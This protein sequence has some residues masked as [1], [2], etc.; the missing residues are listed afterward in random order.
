MQFLV[1]MF[2][3]CGFCKKEKYFSYRK[4]KTWSVLKSVGLT[5]CW[6]LDSFRLNIYMITCDL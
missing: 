6:T 1:L 4:L 3:V 2:T 5:Y